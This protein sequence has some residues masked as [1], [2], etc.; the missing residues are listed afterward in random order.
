MAP[1][2]GATAVTAAP[3]FRQ[4]RCR[5]SEISDPK[6]SAVPRSENRLPRSKKPLVLN[7]NPPTA[8]GAAPRPI[9]TRPSTTNLGSNPASKPGSTTVATHQPIPSARRTEITGDATTAGPKWAA[10]RWLRLW[11]GG[12][13]APTAR[14]GL[15][16]SIQPATAPIT[17]I[18]DVTHRRRTAGSPRV[19]ARATR[20]TT[21]RQMAPSY[22]NVPTASRATA[23]PKRRPVRGSLLATRRAASSMTRL[24]TCGLFVLH[25]WVDA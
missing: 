9:T 7:G 21:P 16:S 19:H 14:L 4:R 23:A 17:T 1:T 13:D 15:V 24:K 10:A 20:P 6:T 11:N 12:G 18:V 2:T 5:T 25:R 3:A 22:A 8:N